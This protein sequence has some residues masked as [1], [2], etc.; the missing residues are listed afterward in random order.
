[1]TRNYVDQQKT[2]VQTCIDSVFRWIKAFF[3][4]FWTREQ[5]VPI[6]ER[7]HS[8]VF[9]FPANYELVRL[10]CF[11]GLKFGT[12][13]VNRNSHFNPQ[14]LKVSFTKCNIYLI[15]LV[16]AVKISFQVLPEVHPLVRWR[17]HQHVSRCMFVRIPKNV[18]AC[19]IQ[20]I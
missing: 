18:K 2:C 9:L 19:I 16:F 12:E 14:I 1:M 17:F 7:N 6:I 3:Q 5:A 4:L 11:Q 13:R 15:S 20:G 8:R 10:E